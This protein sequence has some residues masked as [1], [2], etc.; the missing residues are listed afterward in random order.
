MLQVI[1]A[2]HGETD[3][4][5]ERRVQG[6]SSDTP[7]NEYGR[8][9][10]ARLARRLETV[11]IGAVYSS[12][13]RRARDTAQGIAGSHRLE[14]TVEPDLGEIDAGEL[15]GVQID[16]IGKRLDELLTMPEEALAGV[17]G[18]SW[19]K[20]PHFGGEPLDE[21][22]RRVWGAMERI[23]RR[24]SDGVVVVVSHYFVIITII[25]AVLNL[26]LSQI[27]RLRLGVAGISTIVFDGSVP[28]LTLFNDTCHLQ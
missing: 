27:G 22:Q 1:L 2:R 5:K 13:L 26:P 15:E 3:W 8:E 17:G 14:V 4:N 6:R 20:L 7:L 9:Q 12:P 11:E 16:T 10:A 19:S 21:F 18:G 24:H 25:C 23:A 28:R